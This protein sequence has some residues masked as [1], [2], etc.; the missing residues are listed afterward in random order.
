MEM[1]S[2]TTPEE[3]DAEHER[4]LNI[5]ERLLQSIGLPYQVV[6]MCTGD[7]GVPAARKY[8]LEA[9]FPS[10]GRYRELTSTSSCT[11][12]QARRLNIRYRPSVAA[13]Q[14]AVGQQGRRAGGR[15]AG[16]RFVHTLNGTAFAIGRTISCLMEHGQQ[17][18]GS[19]VLPPTLREAL[20]VERINPVH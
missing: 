6:K 15:A 14:A 19:V 11:D 9:W 5:E 1:F 4:L 12:W 13:G 7:L 17:A 8:D 20:G 18:D 3:S 16:L 10:E 2:F